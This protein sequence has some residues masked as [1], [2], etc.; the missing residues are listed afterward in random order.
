VKNLATIYLEAVGESLSHYEGICYELADRVLRLTDDPE[1]SILYAEAEDGVDL[2]YVGDMAK[3][4]AY[5]AVPLIG[6]LVHDAWFSLASDPLP[7][8]EWVSK[9]FPW[10]CVRMSVFS[11]SKAYGD[12]EGPD[13]TWVVVPEGLPTEVEVGVGS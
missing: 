1:A 9:V 8:D 13:R 3:R 7:P 4:W 10:Q 2:R 11:N 12:G 5:H 6:G